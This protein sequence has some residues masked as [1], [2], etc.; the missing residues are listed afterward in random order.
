MFPAGKGGRCVGLTNLPPSCAECLEI[1]EPQPPGTLRAYL[2]L[3]RDCFTFTYY[4]STC[5]GYH[6]HPSSRAQNNCN[7]SIW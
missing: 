7:Y 5:F 6:Y 2:G 3:Y 1:W 4:C